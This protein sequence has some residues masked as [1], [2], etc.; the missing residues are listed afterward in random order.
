[1]CQVDM[2]KFWNEVLDSFEDFINRTNDM[3]KENV[4]DQ[5]QTYPG[6]DGFFENN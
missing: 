4:Q 1:M 2:E 3:P 6:P 5:T